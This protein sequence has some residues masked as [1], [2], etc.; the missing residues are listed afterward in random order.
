MINFEYL[1]D[2]LEKVLQNPKSV[3]CFKPYDIGN[4]EALFA[5]VK[6]SEG[7][8]KKIQLTKEQSQLEFPFVPITLFKDGPGHS[9][10]KKFMIFDGMI[11]VN[12]D[13]MDGFMF[14]YHEKDKK[15][16]GIF[17]TFIDGSATL[18]ACKKLKKFKE[19][20][21]LGPYTAMLNKNKD[22]KRTH[23]SYLVIE[24]HKTDDDTFIINK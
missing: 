3:V 21:E 16:V 14:K 10:L 9:I 1:D 8:Y 7:V 22:C 19:D 20:G 15:N 24:D 2:N 17:A 23:D 18:V 5:I 11:A 6:E 13:N 12:T 4:K